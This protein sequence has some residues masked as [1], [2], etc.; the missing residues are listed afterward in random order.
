MDNL[1]RLLDNLMHEL[2][3]LGNA[4]LSPDEFNESWDDIITNMIFLRNISEREREEQ[5]IRNL[6]SE[7]FEEDLEDVRV[8][9]TNQQFSKFST[10]NPNKA[11]TKCTICLV[12][13]TSTINITTLPCSHSFHTDC[14]KMWLTQYKVTC[15]VCRTDT[16]SVNA[17]D[18][19]TR[20]VC[21]KL[22]S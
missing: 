9:L 4:E 12:D 2:S 6:F 18:T 1:K 8:T 15:P 17:S 7:F 11:M 16:R 21:D 20:D 13:S 10:S 22:H 14:I 19:T 5:F 3:D